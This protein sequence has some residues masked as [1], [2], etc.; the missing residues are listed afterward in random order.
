MPTL[1]QTEEWDLGSSPDGFTSEPAAAPTPAQIAPV[2]A[3]DKAQPVRARVRRAP[4]VVRALRDARAAQAAFHA[5]CDQVEPLLFPEAYARAIEGEM[6]GCTDPRRIYELRSKSAQFRGP[7]ADAAKQ[8][9]QALVTKAFE[10]V[11]A[12]LVNLVDAGERV[13]K[14]LLDEALSDEIRLFTR[15]SV[16]PEPTAVSRTVRGVLEEIANLRG[17]LATNHNFT[18]TK[19]TCSWVVDWFTS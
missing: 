17:A 3:N 16:Q 11:L 7:S 15:H 19:G 12:A 4:E 5:V 13:A 2:P 9:A 6:I 1:P 8:S 14:A 18:I 10:P